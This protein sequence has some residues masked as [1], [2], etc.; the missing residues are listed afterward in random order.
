MLGFYL[1]LID[2]PGDKEKFKEIYYAY[3]DMMF[4]IAMKILHNRSLAEEA[5]Q[6]SFLK[7]AK[8]I[9]K[10]FEPVCSKSACFIVIIV[11]NTSINNLK[12]ENQD[13]KT[14]YNDNINSSDI[15]MPD[16]ERVVSDIGYVGVTEIIESMDNIYGDALTL[17]YIYGY[18]NS[19]LADFLGITQKNAEMRIYR[20]KEIL[21]KKLEENGYAVK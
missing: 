16:F 18:S 8:N 4:H 7:I 14:P 20:G 3:K 1:A 11:R 10:F 5:V 19:E 9:S 21:K 6:D 12:K 2:E 13:Q 17:K 15:T